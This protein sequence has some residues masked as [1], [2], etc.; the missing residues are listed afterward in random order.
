MPGYWEFPGG[1]CEGE[2][3]PEQAARRE[4]LEETGLAVDR[5]VL[6][7]T[8]HHTYPHGSVELSYYDC[9][10]VD[11]LSEPVPSSGF[12]W[13][14]APDLATL[15]FPEANEVILAELISEWSIH[16]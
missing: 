8:I 7:R 16:G 6:R 2:E 11:P 12:L 3:T 5:C 10:L 9:T 13:K 4:A 15:R 14:H 1:K